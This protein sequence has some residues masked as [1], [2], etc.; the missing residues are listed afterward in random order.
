MARPK[1][2]LVVQ[3]ACGG[4]GLPDERQ[5]RKWAGAAALEDLRVTLRLLDE[6]E[7]RALNRRYRDRDYATNVLTF[8][9]PDT[10]P[11]TG[12]IAICIPVAAR[13]AA[14]QRKSLDAHLAHLVV[15]GVL[16]LQG[17]D[18]ERALDAE[19]ME[20][21]ETEILGKLGY[22]DPYGGQRQSA[23]LSGGATRRSGNRGTR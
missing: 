21:I 23:N 13:E 19:L 15:H 14:Q 1:M 5:F 4:A 9:Y 16:H 2:N 10:T 8:A 18:H 3:Y 7:G 20:G 11:L 6:P 17:F 22:A 12:D